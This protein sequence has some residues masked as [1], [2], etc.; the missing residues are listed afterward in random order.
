[1]IEKIEHLS[2]LGE[3]HIHSHGDL[4]FSANVELF[5]KSKGTE[6]KIKSGFNHQTLAGCLNELFDRVQSAVDTVSSNKM[7]EDKQ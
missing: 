2:K 4:T 7:I 5:T 1:M 6:F 3:V